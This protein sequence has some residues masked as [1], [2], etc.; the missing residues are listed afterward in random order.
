MWTPM[1]RE[2]LLWMWF[3]VVFALIKFELKILRKTYLINYGIIPK[4]AACACVEGVE[5]QNKVTDKGITLCV[6]VKV[7]HSPLQQSEK[8]NQDLLCCLLLLSSPPP[9]PNWL[10]SEAKGIKQLE[11]AE[12]SPRWN[13]MK[14]YEITT[15]YGLK[16]PPGGGGGALGYLGGA[17]VRYQN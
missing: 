7:K 13:H 9:P 6:Y 1:R 3:Q 5:E 14:M 4:A 2:H 8:I 15:S 10:K 16:W 11:V 17:Y 12:K